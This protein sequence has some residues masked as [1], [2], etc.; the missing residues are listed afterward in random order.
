MGERKFP[1]AKVG[2]RFG[3][4]TVVATMPRGH[5][6]RSDERVEVKCICG[7]RWQ[8]YVFNLRNRKSGCRHASAEVRP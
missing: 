2:Q 5:R 6:G 4:C 1:P 7:K 8:T 3:A